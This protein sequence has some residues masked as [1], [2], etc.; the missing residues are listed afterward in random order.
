M[1]HVAFQPA[2][3][4][5]VTTPQVGVGWKPSDPMRPVHRPAV[6]ARPPL[7]VRLGQPVISIAES[8]DLLFSMVTGVSAMTVGIAAMTV[9]IG[10]EK[11]TLPGTSRGPSKTWKVI[12]G[13]T[14]TLGAIVILLNMGQLS[15]TSRGASVVTR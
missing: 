14:A 9:G 2:P 12:G 1:N 15:A 4:L 3:P 13:V 6:L 5:P 7:P 8:A 10:G 11:G